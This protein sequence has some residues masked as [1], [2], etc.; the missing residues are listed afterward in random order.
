VHNQE[1]HLDMLTETVTNIVG[2]VIELEKKNEKLSKLVI[3]QKAENVMSKN[4]I[5]GAIINNIIVQ[6]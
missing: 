3:D 2:K 4:E 5:K 6:K 1:T